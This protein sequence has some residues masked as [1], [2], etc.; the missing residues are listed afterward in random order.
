MLL[1]RPRF[2]ADHVALLHGRVRR[3]NVPVA[4]GGGQWREELVPLY[5]VPSFVE[6]LAMREHVYM[7]QGRFHGRRCVA[8][9]S[10]VGSVWAD[11]DYYRTGRRHDGADAVAEDVRR[12][13]EAVG[14][15]DPSFI[16]ATGRGLLASWLTE[17]LPRAALPRWNPVERGV[18]G[19]F[20]GFG[21]DAKCCDAARVFRLLGTT[22]PKAERGHELVRC[23]HPAKG[24]REPEI[25]AFEDVARAILP[26][27]RPDAGRARRRQTGPVRA[28]CQTGA[29]LAGQFDKAG[30]LWARRLDD[31]QRLRAARWFGPL[32]AGQRDVWLFL[33]TVAMSWMVRPNNLRRE[34]LALA[35]EALGGAWTEAQ[36]LS[37]MGAA[38]R[39]AEAAAKGHT[40]AW[41]GQ[42]RDPRYAYRTATIVDELAITFEEQI[43]AGLQTLVSPERRSQLQ[44][45]RGRA[46]GRARRKAKAERDGRIRALKAEGLSHRAIA[47]AVKVGAAT[48]HRVI[49]EPV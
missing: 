14:L 7:G 30:L 13:A 8:Q 25:H 43:E 39:R 21:A 1:T 18:I 26:R 27:E 42:R 37:N 5:A 49:R 11:L 28:V 44:A 48:V 12:R 32:P 6:Q 31:L 35:R 38:V 47:A 45:E 9:L 23:L 16:L 22:N 20:N 46:S 19:A 34:V 29:D 40:V 41:R 4:F 33:A 2:P 24:R 17:E 3:G 15:P 10:T 36:V